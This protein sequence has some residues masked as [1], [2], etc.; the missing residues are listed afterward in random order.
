MGKD[1]KMVE[2]EEN[3]LID[4]ELRDLVKT[5]R[6]IK[7]PIIKFYHRITGSSKTFLDYQIPAAKDNFKTWATSFRGGVILL[8]MC[9]VIFIPIIANDIVYFDLFMVAMIYSIYAASWDLLAGVTGQVSFGHSAFFGIGGYVFIF[10]LINPWIQIHWVL[11]I[12]IGAISTVLIGLIIAVPA[13]RLKGPYLALGTMAFS[14]ML[15]NIFQFPELQ[16]ESI[17]VPKRLNIWRI[18][19]LGPMGEFIII[20]IFMIISVLIMLIVYNSK[21]GTIFQGIRDDE[22]ATEASGINTTKYKLISFMISAFFAGIAGV[23]YVF[24]LGNV[25]FHNFSNT[26]S[27]FPVIFAILGGVASISGAVMGAFTFALLTKLI[28]EIMD[29]ISLII[30][31]P[32]WLTTQ[33]ETISSFIFAIILLIMIRSVERGIMDP[34]IRHTKSLWDLLMGK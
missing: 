12:F 21:L 23:L 24:H 30:T 7:E 31:L 4:E 33:I 26:L 13:L 20:L 18:T 19:T 22:N 28:G 34:A 5:S 16:A 27:F 15:F 14:L 8:T 32:T 2:K 9:L 3:L 25:S 17:D 6:S 29:F 1:W 11:A 10:C